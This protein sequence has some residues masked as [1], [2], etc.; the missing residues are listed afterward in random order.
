MPPKS[1]LPLV[2]TLFASDKSPLL[3]RAGLG[4]APGRGRQVTGELPVSAVL[5]EQCGGAPGFRKDQVPW[6]RA[7]RVDISAVLLQLYLSD[8]ILPGKTL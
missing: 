4:D 5:A 1:A 6:L 7:D 2:K 3:E 8:E